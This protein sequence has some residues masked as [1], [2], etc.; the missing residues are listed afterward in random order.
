[1]SKIFN[2]DNF[3]ILVGFIGLCIAPWLTLALVAAFFAGVFAMT[4]AKSGVSSSVE[5]DVGDED[6]T[7]EWPAIEFPN[8]AAAIA[9]EKAVAEARVLKAKY[10]DAKKSAQNAKRTATIIKIVFGLLFVLVM[11]H[12]YL[13]I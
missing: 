11:A 10:E 12:K 1:M 13:S 2:L 7:I 3:W 4:K 6:S 5:P 8:V 9:E